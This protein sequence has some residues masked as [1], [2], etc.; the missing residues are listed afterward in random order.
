MDD[1]TRNAVRNFLRDEL[2]VE[3]RTKLENGYTVVIAALVLEGIPI[4]VDES[5][6][7]IRNE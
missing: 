6:I 7:K 5:P 4:S 3:V 2:R 1:E